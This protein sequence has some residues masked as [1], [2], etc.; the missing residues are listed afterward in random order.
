MAVDSTNKTISSTD[1]GFPTYLNFDRLR[2]DAIAYL[3]DLTGKI[4]T[5]YNVHDPGITIIEALIYALLDLG[6]R[7]NLPAVDL[8]TRAPGETK[9]DNNF[10]TPAQI[11]TNNPL[12]IIDFRKLL[13][14]I[15]GVKNAWLE[16]ENNLPVDPC[17]KE[18]PVPGAIA[19][20]QRGN[21]DCDF[22]NGLYHVFIELEK[23]YD[24]TISKDADEYSDIIYKI[25]CALMSHRNLCEDFIDIKILCKLKIGLCAD[26]ELEEN[27]AAEDVY[28]TMIEALRDF[29]S[30]SPKFYTLL[31]LLE[32][33][34]SIEDIFA[35][36]PYNLQQSFGFVDTDEFE[37]ITLRK[38]M[39]LS[40]LYH[41]LFDIDGV[42]NVRNLAWKLC[43]GAGPQPDIINKWELH[44]PENFIP[45]FDIACAG[46]QFYKYGMKVKVDTTKANS[47]FAMN[48]S[49]DGKILYTQPSPYLDGEIPQGIFHNDL[50]EYNSIQ[51]D[52]PHVYGIRKGDLSA[53]ASNQRKAQALQLQG[54]LLFFDQLLANY[55]SQLANIR[56]LFAL[57]CGDEADRHTYFTNTL[58]DVPQLDKLL[59]FNTGTDDNTLGSEGSI[60]AYPTSR[61]NLEDLIASGKI[62]N[63][64]LDRRCNDVNKDDFPPYRFCF[65]VMCGQ[66]QNQL[67]DDLLNGD[68]EPVVIANYNDCY[69]FYCFTSSTSFAL[70]SKRYYSSQQEAQ[71]AAA[72]IK[73]LGTFAENYHSFMLDDDPA[74]QFF[75]FD[76]E[77][78]LN[79]YSK[80]LQLIAEDDNLYLKRRQGFLNHLLSRFAEQFTDYALITA[81]F[82][83]P[84][85]IQRSQIKKEERFFSHYP[86]LSSNRGK[87]YDYKCDGW[88]NDN[89][90]GFEK[91]VKALSGIDN[92][93]KHYL[94][95]FVVEKADAIYQLSVSLFGSA[96]EVKDKM[97]TYEAAYSS[98]NSLYK[99]LG[100]NPSLETEYIAHE[101]KWSVFIKDDYGNKYSD[102][103]LFDTEDAAKQFASSLH[104]ILINNP[105]ADANVFISKYVYKVLFKASDDAVIEESKEKFDTPADA[106]K[107]FDKINAR[108]TNYLNDST[109]FGKIKKGIRPE[110]P[111]LLKNE[112][113]DALYIDQH[114]FEFK[115]VDVIQLDSVKKKF[116]LLNDQKTIQFDSLITYDT[117]KLATSG[118][119]QLL[120]LLTSS[121]NYQT[122]KDN[123]DNTFKI[124]INDR[125]ND[126]AIYFQ[127]FN[128][129]QEA[130]KK[131][132]EIFDEIIS[133]TFHLIISDP[134]PD[135]WE[136]KYE[137]IDPAGKNIEFSTQEGFTTQLQAQAAAKKFYAHLPVLKT[138][139]AKNELQLILDQKKQIIAHTSLP[140][141]S[142]DAVDRLLL[143]HQQLFNMVNHPD[144]KLMDATLATGK[145]TNSEP[146]IY[147]L[148]DKDHLVAISNYVLPTLN[149]ALNKK[150]D[151]IN[152]IQAGY[153]YTKISFGA[154]VI[155][156]RK[157]AVTNITW[158]HYVIKC[159]NVLYQKG[160]LKGQ[161][162]ILFES[163]QGYASVEEAQQAFQDNYLVILRKG[164]VDTNYGAGKFMSLSEILVHETSDCNKNAS[165]VFVR[166]ET[167]YEFNGDT[168][169]T[170]NEI[171]LLAKSYPILYISK[172]RYRF[173]LFNKQVDS[174]DWR[175]TDWYSTPLEAMQH[176]QFFLSLLNYSGNIYIEK[177]ETDCRYR[178]YIR[179]VLAIS[180]GSFATPEEA[181]G[182]N[183]VEKMICVAQSENGFHTYLN[184]INCSHSFFI[185]CGNTG[186]VHPCKYET[187]E[188]RDNILN[189]LYQAA[190]FN[191]F[192]L[193]QPDADN[194]LLN[195]L[196][197]NPV[198][199]LFIRQNNNSQVDA[200][201]KLI[202]VFEAMYVDE[203]YVLDG[204][205]F[206]LRDVYKIKI[207][208]PASTTVSLDAW[209]QQLRS[210]AC[211]FP[212]FRK[213]SITAKDIRR[214]IAC[215][216]YIQIKLPGFNNCKDDLAN[217]CPDI[218][219]DDDCNPGC[220]IAWKSDCCFY[221][222]C[223]AML[224]YFSSLK[225]IANFANYKPVYECNCRD[226]GI[227][228]HDEEINAGNTSAANT[229]TMPQWLCGD[230]FNEA[231]NVDNLQR[232]F[233]NKCLNEIVAINPQSYSS[234]EV[235]CSAVSR[236]KKLINSEGLH[237]TEHILL[238]PR[239]IED[240]NCDYLPQSCETSKNVA[241][242][243]I[244]H[245]TW[246]PGGTVDPCV[247]NEIIC[248]SPG[249][250]PYSFIATVALPAWPARF[251]TAEN[252]A[253][254]EKLLQK[255]APAHVL[256]RILWLN[257][258]DFYCFE[259]YFK[260]WNYWLAKKMCDPLYNN[261]DFLGFLFHKNF[262]TLDDC[263]ECVPC[264]CN[265]IPPVSCFDEEQDPCAGFDLVTQLNDL[266]CW[267]DGV[268]DTY[269]CE[270][271][272]EATIG[273]AVVK[274][275]VDLP[276]VAITEPKII[277]EPAR[278]EPANKPSLDDHEKYLLIQSRYSKYAGNVQQVVNAKAGNKAA[279]DALRFLADTDP[280][281]ERYDELLNKILKN[282]PDKTNHIAGL[283]AKE[284]NI[285]IDNISWQYFDRIFLKQ[286][287]AHSVKTN[288]ALFNHLRKNK[289]NMQ[290]L[291]DDWNGKE[292]QTIDPAINLK[293]IK[294]VVV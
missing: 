175:S 227:E 287:T 79:A 228:L 151:L 155:D 160:M 257:P 141:E 214:Q 193:L 23:E 138:Q 101:Q 209:K 29:F 173:S 292:L 288:R 203:N 89:I 284:K 276:N 33:G 169:A 46:F 65:D 10:F 18:V 241:N 178:I 168:T 70:I 225:T 282:K 264:S 137:L 237:L 226:Y 248:F 159:S 170:I 128:T 186:L 283:T 293:K 118:F 142:T 26:I 86:D 196:N 78:N 134:V 99:K 272:E 13:I 20:R 88:D 144:K 83:T 71:T 68:F 229:A 148:V 22:L 104:F 131:V 132:Q 182:V 82:E 9:N 48:F 234:S 38:K 235:A 224:F 252:K 218:Y 244:C 289:I 49:A 222:C 215:N 259:Y 67:R 216:F 62:Q 150:N 6:Y 291:F 260:K 217:N 97:F 111:V 72:S 243:N 279:E 74:N 174:Y 113:Y 269:N 108:L 24:L 139:P 253:V 194:I 165:I 129:Q 158:Y 262:Q 124:K 255:E 221:S 130:Q 17:K 4:W 278:L 197:K 15:S 275:E 239:C 51:N 92:W 106:Q 34:K 140:A 267:N 73:Y 31:Q 153:D 212:L 290:Q 110:K 114:K 249:C 103:N 44:L 280:K 105:E 207:A 263:N 208:S 246:K 40:D 210:I 7:T 268:Y 167:L 258:R 59:R 36:R 136:F 176:F 172:G 146:Y 189:K 162:L 77:L 2:S 102:Q 90:S 233:Y 185:A 195:D 76:I 204:T 35:G 123:G 85:Q 1:S 8:F 52:F 152:A 12:A 119:Q 11:L 66:A 145:Q 273:R 256:L 84:L 32:K 112:N 127:S 154:D 81:G 43:N 220:Y 180:M 181:W 95:N 219:S 281:P 199:Y 3:G 143:Q 19:N 242:S 125:K 147:K 56:S 205:T 100:E 191:F 240:C 294:K 25:K 274:K 183:G 53:T 94:C 57:S 80:Y 21:C 14:D 75:S 190:S 30:P 236:A 117:V 163:T 16:V 286:G 245:F 93:K 91:R 202:E 157:E 177:Y 54:F 50:A 179:E 271:V 41:L 198:A 98:L 39:H 184:R 45:E 135:K 200:C 69:F 60:L 5:D 285:L 187:P 277:S 116:A 161:P 115:P 270:N 133:H 126:V 250:D 247:A 121:G 107:Y 254:I 223:E 61:K 231:G 261:C 211:Y 188:R 164:F 109:E 47:I 27:A 156:E 230:V 251:R 96:F 232:N 192:D 149:D 171:I 266:Y 201:E 63:T 64:D 213:P 206:Y 120:G 87:G 238:R 122:S 58:S 55:L 37:K 166:P 42:K 265:E 28:L